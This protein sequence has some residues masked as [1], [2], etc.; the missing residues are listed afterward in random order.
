MVRDGSANTLL[1]TADE[2]VFTPEMEGREF[3][4]VT[5]KYGEAVDVYK[6]QGRSRATAACWWMKTTI[7][8]SLPWFP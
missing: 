3:L 1:A 5:R 2:D 4:R 8:G 7:S 6:R